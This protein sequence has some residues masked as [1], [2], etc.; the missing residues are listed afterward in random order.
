MPFSRHLRASVWSNDVRRHLRCRL[1]TTSEIASVA[2]V[3]EAIDDSA[4]Q[5]YVHHEFLPLAGQPNR[6]FI[7]MS[8]LDE[9]FR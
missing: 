4:R 8:T 9:L 6:L 2:V 7:A 5:F 3:A 1:G